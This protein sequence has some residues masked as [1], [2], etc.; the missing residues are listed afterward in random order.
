MRIDVYIPLFLPLLLTAA[1]AQ[2]GR[3]ISP[4]PAARVLTVAAVLTAAASTW[5]LLLLAAT[6]VNEAPLVATETGETG[7]ACPSRCRWPSPSPRSP[8][9]G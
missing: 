4:A 8:F 3:R 2:V 1:A 9:S 7:G 6:L 5:A